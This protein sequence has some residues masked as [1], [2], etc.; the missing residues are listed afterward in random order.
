M[1]PDTPAL[2]QV[3]AEYCHQV[4]GGTP[5]AVA[6]LFHRQAVLKPYFDGRYEVSGRDDIE[7][8]YAHYEAL[9]KAKIRH[10]RHHLGC[11]WIRVAGHAAQASTHF[12]ATWMAAD[13][14][15][16]TFAQGTYTDTLVQDAG[17]WQFMMRQ[18]DIGFLAGLPQAREQFASLGWPPAATGAT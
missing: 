5:A 16:A 6:A 11:P 8:W 15:E 13:T 7:R 2:E 10:L 9:F 17:R 14:G 18:I 4:D 1:N 3:L 12:I